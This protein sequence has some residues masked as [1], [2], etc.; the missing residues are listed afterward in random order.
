PIKTTKLNDAELT[1]STKPIEQLTTTDKL[2]LFEGLRLHDSSFSNLNQKVA[3]LWTNWPYPATT[4]V[5]QRRAHPRVTH[6]FRR[7]DRLRPGDEVAAG[8]PSV[9]NPFPK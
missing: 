7:G 9:L 4:M 8:V 5:L 3:N 1:H 6:I 2:S